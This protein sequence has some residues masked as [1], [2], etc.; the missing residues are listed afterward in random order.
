M[1]DLLLRLKCRAGTF[2]LVVPLTCTLSDL[3]E[4][5]SALS[6][7]PVASI[8]LLL[9]FPPKPIQTYEGSV[10]DA[11]LKTGDLIIAEL[12]SSS[13]NVQQVKV[14][15]ESSVLKHVT[16]QEVGDGVPLI[17]RK[18]VPADNSCLFTSMGYVL[19]GNINSNIFV[20]RAIKY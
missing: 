15:T 11:G 10:E 14:E 9:G 3:R 6:E 8:K 18:V 5:V 20:F 1:S 17:L 13:T 2:K 7:I 19:G 16:E 4:Q 12:D